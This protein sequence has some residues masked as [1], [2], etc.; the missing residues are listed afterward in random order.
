[1]FSAEQSKKGNVALTPALCTVLDPHMTIIH[2]FLY[3]KPAMMLKILRNESILR[4]SS[5]VAL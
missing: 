2:A 5:E 1:M 3:S 4:E